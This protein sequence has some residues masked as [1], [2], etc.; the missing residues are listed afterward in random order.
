MREVAK[1]AE[2]FVCGDKN[3]CG[4]KARFFAQDDGSVKSSYVVE[5][6]FVGYTDILHG[7]VLASLLDEV[8]IKAVLN[9]MKLAVTASMEIKYK[10]PV[11]VGQKIDLIGRILKKKHRI[12]WTEG[13]AHVNGNM[14]ASSSAI[15]VEAKGDLAS[16]LAQSLE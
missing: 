3:Q 9:E 4:L 1:F 13:F 10:M 15:Y 8:M 11:Y 12:F 2:C 16:K 6:R 7:G 5:Q 14:V